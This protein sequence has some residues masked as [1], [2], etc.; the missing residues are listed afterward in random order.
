MNIELRKD[1]TP[2]KKKDPVAH[3]AGIGVALGTAFG[4]AFGD[5]AI[6]MVMGLVIGTSWGAFQGNDARGVKRKNLEGEDARARR[7][8]DAGDGGDPV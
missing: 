4:A 5:V 6:G 1:K 7:E 8:L 2:D 3:F